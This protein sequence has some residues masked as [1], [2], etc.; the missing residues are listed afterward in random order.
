MAA[1]PPPLTPAQRARS[2]QR[3]AEVRRERSRMLADLTA[4]RI[5][6]RDVLERRD[7]MVGRTLVRRLVECR[8]GVG[9]VRA[10]RYLEELGIAGS[11][12]VRGLGPR[13]RARLLELFPPTGPEPTAPG[14]PKPA[15]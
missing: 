8:P 2:L 10:A 3:A 6:L 15:P 13:Q 9:K 12:R 14:T 11:R 5:T 1:P 4:G 7:E